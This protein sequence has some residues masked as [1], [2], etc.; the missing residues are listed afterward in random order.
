MRRKLTGTKTLAKEVIGRGRDVGEV[1]HT[2]MSEKE[3]V[4]NAGGWQ[5]MSAH[6]EK[7]VADHWSQL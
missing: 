7:E 2:K 4:G 1:S 6:S 3:P 5:E